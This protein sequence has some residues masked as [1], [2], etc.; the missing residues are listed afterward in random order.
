MLTGSGAGVD[1]QGDRIGA[2]AVGTVA[3]G[4]A[5]VLARSV[6]PVDLPCPVLAVTG[7]PCP[8]CGLTRLAHAAVHGRFVDALTT[9]P[10]GVALLALV[11]AV[12]ALHLVGRRR[13][14]PRLTIPPGTVVVMVVVLTAVHW[15]TTLSGGLLDA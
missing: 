7:V 12:A 5:L 4:A 3:F 15:I 14:R 2:A 1:E 6:A 11:A 8:A 13:S 10:A 9:D